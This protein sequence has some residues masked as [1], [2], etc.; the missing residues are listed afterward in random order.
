MKIK[1]IFFFLAISFLVPFF[2]VGA[3]SFYYDSNCNAFEKGDEVILEIGFNDNDYSIE[4]IEGSLVFDE[5]S[6]L[7]K[8]VKKDNSVLDY[9]GEDPYL[10]EVGVIFFNGG[11]EAGFNEKEG[12]LFSLI[13]EAIDNGITDLNFSSGAILTKEENGEHNLNLL[14]DSNKVKGEELS[15]NDVFKINSK[16]HPE[17]NVWYTEK[18]VLFNWGIPEDVQKIKIL[19][20]E[21]KDSYPSVE[22]T[23]LIKEKNVELED[24]V[25]YMHG[26]YFGDD[27]WSEV[28]HKKVMID[29]TKPDF[30][31]IE[32]GEERIPFLKFEASDKMSGIKNYQIE[33][34]SEDYSFSTTEKYLEFPTAKAGEYNVIF[35]AFDNAG[36]FLQEEKVVEINFLKSPSLSKIELDN[37]GG[38]LIEGFTKYPNSKVYILLA[39]RESL[40]EV[41]R[42]S[43]NGYFN[44]YKGDIDPGSYELFLMTITEDGASGKDK[45]ATFKVEEIQNN[46]VSLDEEKKTVFSV[47]IVLV[48]IVVISFLA[49]NFANEQDK[50]KK[51]RKIKK[52]NKSK[53]K[54]SL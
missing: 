48:V 52:K 37:N 15:D 23:E 13:F 11:I 28:D 46:F 18:D 1:P 21:E 39:G 27:G 42:T 32:I 49:R 50:K 6:L 34:P 8:E 38:I 26:R 3:T 9:F 35:K 7:L 44:F 33:I 45:K 2:N 10:K 36:N 14:T 17:S 12:K 5:D 24:G 20:D 31:N 29:S 43:P 16:T 53:N 54:N 30:L 4:A 19:I 22:Y 25:W 51:K 40:E 47:V 41:V